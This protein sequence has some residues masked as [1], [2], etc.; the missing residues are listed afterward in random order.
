[1]VSR[2]LPSDVLYFRGNFKFRSRHS[3]VTIFNSCTNVEYRYTSYHLGRTKT[4]YKRYLYQNTTSST[5]NLIR[6]HRSIL[7]SET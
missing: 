6:R 1:M 7:R 3:V 5:R 2:Y 4:L